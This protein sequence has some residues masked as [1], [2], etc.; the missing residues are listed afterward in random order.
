MTK[1][2]TDPES[3]LT[4]EELDTLLKEDARM[5]NATSAKMTV[6]VTGAVMARVRKMPFLQPA[7]NAVMRRRRRAV[8]AVAVM[9][10]LATGGAGAGQYQTKVADER[11]A[12]MF[13]SV[14][15]FDYGHSSSV[16]MNES[17]VGQLL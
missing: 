12:S 3:G 5:C 14:Y 1:T 13:S 10:I 15:D 9:V 8:A 6:D 11:L 17:S 7:P 4:F 16:Y 2:I